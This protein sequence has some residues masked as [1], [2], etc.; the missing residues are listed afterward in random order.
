MIQH[1]IRNQDTDFNNVWDI[2]KRIIAV[3]R[4]EMFEN[5]KMALLEAGCEG[6]N[7]SAVKGRGRQLGIRES[8]R[9]SS[10]CIDLIPKTR[11]ELIVNEND[12]DR[13]ID[14]I[15]ESARTGDVGDGKIFVS[16]VEEVIRIRTGERG[17]D[18][19]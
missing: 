14:V 4:E 8:Y 12:L 7:V 13:I 5:V 6:M 19:V 9:G 17:S 11:V 18:A 16:D 10:Y 15:V 1:Y 3:I 2:M